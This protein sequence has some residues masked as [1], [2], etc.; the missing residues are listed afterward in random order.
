MTILLDAVGNGVVSEDIVHFGGTV[1]LMLSGV[2]DGGTVEVQINQDNLGFVT[3][4]QDTPFTQPDV[5]DLLFTKGTVYRLAVVG[6]G[7][8]AAIS[9]S[10][11]I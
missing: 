6:A 2:F 9:A 1:Q 3:L 10:I 5:N 8:S 11:L 4:V 7:G